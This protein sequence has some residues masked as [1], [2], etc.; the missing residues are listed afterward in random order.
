[1]AVE[2]RS[3][4]KTIEDWRSYIPLAPGL[5]GSSGSPSLTGV[6]PPLPS[7]HYIP[8]LHL[9]SPTRRYIH[10]PI[11]EDR[12]I[13]GDITKFKPAVTFEG[14]LNLESFLFSLNQSLCKYKLTSDEN[15]LIA[16]GDSLWGEALCW[17][18]HQRFE[19][20]ADAVTSLKDQFKDVGHLGDYLQKLNQLTQRGTT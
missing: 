18:T 12:S 19:T 10:S 15:K 7:Q 20:Y 6:V 4:D 1:M 2:K 17:W 14:S 13:E 9:R 11:L 8:P 5:R 3:H 16:L